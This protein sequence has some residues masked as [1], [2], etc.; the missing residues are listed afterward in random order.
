MAI[1]RKTYLDTQ[2]KLLELSREIRELPLEDMLEAIETC[3]AMAPVLDPTAFRHG[4]KNLAIVKRLV[5][6]ALAF[7]FSL[8]DVATILEGAAAAEGYQPVPPP[9]TR[10]AG[11]KAFADDELATIHEDLRREH[12]RS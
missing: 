8:P 1:D 2:R 12:L 4:N 3:E 11:A 6:G 7:K 5:N 9:A 10:R